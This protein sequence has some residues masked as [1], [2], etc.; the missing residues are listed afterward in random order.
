MATV[1]TVPCQYKTGKILGQGT[2]AVVKEAQHIKTGQMFAVKVINKKLMEGR[3]HMVRNEIAVL[4]RV[5]QGNKNIL[6]LV[7]YFETMNNLYLVTEL[8]EGGELFDRIC[9]KGQFYERDAAN[10]VRSIT[11]AVAYLH[12]N[13]IVHRDLKPENLLFRTRAD[14]SDLLVADFGLSKIIDSETFHVLTTTCGTPGYMA[15][16]ILAKEGHGKPVDLWSIGVITYF[17]LCGYTPFERDDSLAETKAILEADYKFEPVEYWEGVSDIAIDF[18]KKLLTRDPRKRLTAVDALHHQWLSSLSS[19][20]IPRDLLTN[21]RQ[22]FNARRT[23]RKAVDA[24]KMIN[25]LNTLTRSGSGSSLA[26]AGLL[27]KSRAE[28]DEDVDQSILA[29]KLLLIAQYNKEN[30]AHKKKRLLFGIDMSKNYLQEAHVTYTI[31]SDRNYVETHA[32][33]HTHLNPSTNTGVPITGTYRT[34]APGSQSKYVR[35]TTKHSDLAENYYFQRDARRDYPRLSVFT[36]KDVALLFA[37]SNMKSITAG[38]NGAEKG[39]DVTATTDT[40]TDIS[41][42]AENMSLTDIIA[43]LPKPLYSKDKLPPVP[44]KGSHQWEYSKDADRPDPGQNNIPQQQTATT[45]ISQTNTKKDKITTSTAITETTTN[46][47]TNRTVHSKAWLHLVAGGV[48]GMAGALV[49]CPLDVSSYYSKIG[50]NKVTTRPSTI[51]MLGKFIDTGKIL[52]VIYRDEGWRA[53]FK[54]LGPNLVGVVP[55][56]AIN[57]FAY[58]NG[59]RILTDLNGGQETAMVHGIAAILAGL[60]TSTATNP[61]WLVKTRMQLQS[62]TGKLLF[63][64]KKYRNSVDCVIT[65]VKEEGIKGLYRGLSASYLA[66]LSKRRQGQHKMEPDDVETL[67]R[68]KDYWHLLDYFLAAGSSKLFA[69]GLTYPHEVL[70][71]RLRQLPNERVKYTGLI[72]CAKTIIRNEGLTAMYGGLTAHLMRVVPNTAI[73]FFCYE[74]ILHY[75]GTEQTQK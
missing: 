62:S 17:L 19:V 40:T 48:G 58:G 44:N 5:S 34:P 27:E 2:Y 10:I 7:D 22:N 13:G 57:F 9:E 25:T 74:L 15:P 32:K 45:T 28:A 52:G 3:E 60:A 46:I 36:Q 21:V 68:S 30:S 4:K 66:T 64:I 54:G 56:R 75:A 24:V 69:A 12:E 65:V 50:P 55:A 53:L 6:T 31:I 16:E 14:D 59:K 1:S 73:M 29:F 70:R 67:V 61:I 18:I 11:E 38:G 41:K 43:A 8:A 47:I 71:T 42:I 33:C 51:P 26:V 20:N 49:T 72:H 37:A 39:T 63:P 35:P 23:F